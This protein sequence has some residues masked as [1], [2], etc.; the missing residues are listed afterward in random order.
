ML[1]FIICYL[2]AFGLVSSSFAFN[3]KSL[4]I[5]ISEWNH[6]P[7]NIKGFKSALREAGF[8]EGQ[9]VFFH[10]SSAKGNQA[11]QENIANHFLEANYDLI[12]SLTT[13]GTIALKKR[14]KNVP[15]VFSI[16]TYPAD[17]G[18]IESF[19]Y[20]GNNLVG[21]SN[22]VPIQHY[23]NLTKAFFSTTKKVAVIHRK[24]EPNSNIQAMN[25]KRQ[26]AKLNIET[27]D[28]QPSTIQEVS[29]LLEQAISNIDLIITTTDTL[30][31]NGGE[32]VIIELAN[33]HRLPI[34][35]SNKL[36]IQK[37]ATLG[38]VVDFYAL[39]KASGEL[40]VEILKN[41]AKPSALSSSYIKKPSILI[42]RKN[43]MA[44]GLTL[45]TD[46]SDIIY[47]E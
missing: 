10:Q 5:G 30:I 13:P 21:T 4:H 7:E 12:Y 11:E 9:N 33:Q 23:I 45:P 19:D 6:Y 38:P 16:V 25:L 2:L 18:I 8:I 41:K 32:E 28:L 40:A 31:Q 15:I 1:R 35:S 26:L 43:F 44:L 22:F 29:V 46:S 20:S 37:G 34:L 17:A 3:A 39:G 42:N 24:G 14:I 36:G 27:V 47:V